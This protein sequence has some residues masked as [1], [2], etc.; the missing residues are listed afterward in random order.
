MHTQ[1]EAGNESQITDEQGN[2]TSETTKDLSSNT[3]EKSS[4]LNDL[5]IVDEEE[6]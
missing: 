2:G 3:T 4:I 1:N 5:D 6:N